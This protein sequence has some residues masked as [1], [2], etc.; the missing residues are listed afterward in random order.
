MSHTGPAL[1]A[2]QE[3]EILKQN[4]VSPSAFIWTHAQ[5]EPDFNKHIE[6]AKMGVW[7]AFD[8]FNPSQLERYVE[9]AQLM[10]KEGLL[11]KVLFSHDA[12]WYKPG[13]PGGGEFRGFTEI[14]EYLIPALEK[15]GIS[16][17]GIYQLFN[18]N[19]AEA[20]K[21]KVRLGE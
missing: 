10:K 3:I 14:E 7:I 18:A 11:N 1:P 9:F 20:F 15:N 12:G 17:H 4:G 16:Q 6:A 2:F 21:V 13:E 19:P 5:N 8:N